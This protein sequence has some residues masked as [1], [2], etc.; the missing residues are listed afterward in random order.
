[1]SWTR[2]EIMHLGHF[3]VMS[4]SHPELATLHIHTLADLPQLREEYSSEQ[5]STALICLHSIKLWSKGKEK[6]PVCVH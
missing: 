3:T 4:I 1:M 5:G 6:V 2:R